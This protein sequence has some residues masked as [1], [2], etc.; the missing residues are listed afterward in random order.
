M[1]F[2]FDC[3]GIDKNESKESFIFK[4]HEC[5]DRYFL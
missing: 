2:Y 3:K 1:L 4:I 5:D